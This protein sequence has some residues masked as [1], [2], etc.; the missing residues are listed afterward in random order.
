VRERGRHVTPGT[1]SATYLYDGL[2]APP[3]DIVAALV[4][5]GGASRRMGQDKTR[6]LIDGATLG[7]RIG[8]LASRACSLA[9]EVGPGVTG[10]P[11][12]V[13]DPP[14]AGPLV[15]IASG[16]DELRRRGHSGPALVVAC[17]L[18]FLSDQLVRALVDWD[19][20][21]SVVPVVR[22]IPQP[23]CARWSARDLDGTRGL[24]D[25]GVRT[26]MHVASQRDAVCLSEVAWTRFASE[27]DFADIDSHAD[28][29]QFG[30]QPEF[31]A[32]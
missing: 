29:A 8:Q 20:P 1:S 19:A 22:G 17:D 10:L 27:R 23:L 16:R 25:A 21:G 13:E 24:V 7:A 30:L 32:E 4:L 11:S 9:I 14:G 26:V 3:S 15:A 6:L 18:P 12:V 2:M 28:L 31:S 5:S